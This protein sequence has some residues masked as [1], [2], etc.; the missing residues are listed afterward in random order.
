[1][2]LIRFDNSGRQGSSWNLSEKQGQIEKFATAI[3]FD[4]SKEVGISRFTNVVT[5]QYCRLLCFLIA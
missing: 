2:Y 5:G 4:D 3:E 1:M